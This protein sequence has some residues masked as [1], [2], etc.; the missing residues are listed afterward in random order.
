M[1]PN[2]HKLLKKYNI[3]NLWKMGPR[4]PTTTRMHSKKYK[5]TI[6]IQTMEKYKRY[7]QNNHK[8]TQLNHD[9]YA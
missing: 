6:H 4:N 1:D 2:Y 8:T 5:N 3:L 9:R 7:I